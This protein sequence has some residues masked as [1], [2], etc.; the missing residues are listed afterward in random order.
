MSDTRFQSF[1]E[2]WPYYVGEHRSPTTRA[3]HYA[4]TGAALTVAGFGLLTLNPFMVPFAL[5]CGYG[6]AWVSHFFV[7]DNKPA[8]FD[9]PLWSFMADFKML[10]YALTG[11][12]GREVTRLYGSTNPSR[13]APLL[14]PA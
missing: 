1:D 11:R 10:W 3:L 14:V 6:P 12:M 5:V 9:Y 7:E 2:F 4:G 8:T 13:D